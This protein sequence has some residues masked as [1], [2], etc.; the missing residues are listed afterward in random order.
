MITHRQYK[1]HI[2]TYSM[3]FGIKV[4]M[5]LGVTPFVFKW[6]WPTVVLLPSLQRGGPFSASV[7]FLRMCSPEAR[8]TFTEAAGFPEPARQWSDASGTTCSVD[9]FCI[10]RDV[11]DQLAAA[12][13]ARA[14]V[15][16]SAERPQQALEAPVREGLYGHLLFP[17]LQGD[18]KDAPRSGAPVG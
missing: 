2:N 18:R 17:L 5:L 14:T 16:A 12:A 9:L 7:P 15:A 11:W 4:F 10:P 1:D 6:P 3:P 8:S 13:T